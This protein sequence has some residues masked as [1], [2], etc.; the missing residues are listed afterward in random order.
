VV[1]IP[2]DQPEEEIDDYERKE[3]EGFKTTAKNAVTGSGSVA[4]WG[5]LS[6]PSIHC[7][8]FHECCGCC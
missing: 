7:I 8:S 5:T 3:K 1:I 4:E 2:G 6:Q